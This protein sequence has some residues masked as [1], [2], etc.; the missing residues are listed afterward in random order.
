MG[1]PGVEPAGEGGGLGGLLHRDY[2]RAG[3]SAG[4]VGVQILH[5]A[6]G[7]FLDLIVVCRPADPQ[8]DLGGVGQSN[9]T[10]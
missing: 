3:I 7:R 4:R 6:G 8:K 1:V 2:G 10:D 9:P 5:R